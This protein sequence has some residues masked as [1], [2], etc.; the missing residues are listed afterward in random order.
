MD[1]RIRKYVLYKVQRRE[2]SRREL[3]N[4][5]SLRNKLRQEIIDESPSV[6]DGQ[7]RGKGGTSDVT[8]RKALKLIEL[9]RRIDK[10]GHE[11][12][13]I[14]S[15]EERIYQMGHVTK[16][17]YN[18]TIKK[19]CA[20]LTAKAQLIGIGRTRLIQGRAKILEL[21]ATE[22]GEYTNM[23]E[24]QNDIETMNRKRGI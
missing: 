23:I 18:E 9:D 2:K 14:K 10:L 8:Q 19:E 16:E 13:V 20:D 6:P 5:T 7:P 12:S 15:V 24:L 1:K 11:L 3:E 17:I 22:L 4:L 21:F